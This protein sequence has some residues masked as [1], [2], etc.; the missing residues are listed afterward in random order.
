MTENAKELITCASKTLDEKKGRNIVCLDLSGIHS[1]LEYFIIATGD[2]RLHLRALA[3]DLTMVLENEGYGKRNV[4]SDESGWIVLD[5]GAVF[6]H[7]FLEEERS[8]FNLE[9]LW[10]DAELIETQTAS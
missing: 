2:S 1:Y 7:L 6:V 5:Y 3:R 10:A 9:K 8:Y 4:P